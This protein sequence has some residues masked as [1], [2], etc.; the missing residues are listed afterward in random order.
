[1]SASYGGI[2][3]LDYDAEKAGTLMLGDVSGML[4]DYEESNCSSSFFRVL[5]LCFFGVERPR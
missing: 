1:M 2:S 4:P 5:G 3:P